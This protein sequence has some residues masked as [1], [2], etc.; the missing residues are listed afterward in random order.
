MN[1]DFQYHWW[2]RI[3]IAVFGHVF[4]ILFGKEKVIQDINGAKV[5]LIWSAITIRT[6]Y[7]ITRIADYGMQ[8]A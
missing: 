6:S 2:S 5:N 1:F 3:G 8:D 7:M 4:E